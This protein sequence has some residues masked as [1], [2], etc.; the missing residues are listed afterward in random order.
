MIADDWTDVQTVD[1]VQIRCDILQL[2]GSTLSLL[3]EFIA[4]QLMFVFTILLRMNL[5]PGKRIHE[6][7]NWVTL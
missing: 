1:A 4:L 5:C 6:I 7:C 2:L 3:K